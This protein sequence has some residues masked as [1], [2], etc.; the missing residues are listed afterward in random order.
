VAER[1]VRTAKGVLDS[2]A[3][4]VAAFTVSTVRYL[5]NTPISPSAS[6]L[7]P[8]Y[9]LV[10]SVSIAPISGLHI[11]LHNHRKK[12]LSFIRTYLSIADEITLFLNI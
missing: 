2:T 7:A 8:D 1:I 10:G 11:D 6:K 4:P 12:C 3:F 9:S 5:F